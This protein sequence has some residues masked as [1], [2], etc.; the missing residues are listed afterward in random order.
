[1]RSAAS[2]ASNRYCASSKGHNREV[3]AD[4]LADLLRWCAAL[5]TDPADLAGAVVLAAGPRWSRLADAPPD[6]REF[7]VRTFLRATEPAEAISR[8]LLDRIPQELRVIVLAYDKLPKLQRAV[9]MLSC[10]DGVT[11]AEIAAILDRSSARMGIE[12][13]RA[14]AVINADPYA[15]RAALDIATWHVP[16]AAEVSRALRRHTKRRARRRHRIGLVGVAI[17]TTLAVLLTV[18]AVHRPHV[19]PRQSGVWTFSH[20]VRPIPGWFIQSRTVERDWETTI[21]RAEQPSDGRCSVAVGSAGATWVRQLPRKPTRIRV[22]TRSANYAEHVWPNGGGAMLWWEY[23]DTAR[24]IIE[25]GRVGNPR[26]TLPQLAGHVTLTAE[27][28]QLPYRIRSL[29]RHYE[30]TSVTRGL[31]NNSTV[32]YLTRNDYP[33]GIIQISIRYP[34][35]LPMYAVNNSASVLRYA[36]GRHAAVC[37]PFGDSHVC[38]RGDLSTPGSIDIAAQPGALAVID[39]IASNL[40]IA[41]SPRDLASWFDAREALPS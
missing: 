24:V 20:T 37:R 2:G 12:L 38:I 32:A 4:E 17:G 36:T 25:C 9:L 16:D 6:L 8:Q 18:G 41:A 22:G 29:P 21:L 35:G 13:D 11:C 15:V 26:K 1:V 10:L 31:V 40:E 3:H 7:T 34:A 23:A 27:S 39:Q 14:L 33:E 30:V 28:V 19:E 5:S